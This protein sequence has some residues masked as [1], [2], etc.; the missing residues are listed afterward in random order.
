MIVGDDGKLSDV[1]VHWQIDLKIP[2]MMKKPNS[3]GY[4]FKDIA[5]FAAQNPIVGDILE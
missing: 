2:S 5:K 4:V 3:V 1:A